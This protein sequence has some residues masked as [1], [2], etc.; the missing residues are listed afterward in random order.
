MAFFPPSKP[1]LDRQEG[2]GAFLNK[3]FIS[4]QN[5]SCF[6]NSGPP[7][8]ST[9][10]GREAQ[11]RG[12]QSIDVKSSRADP[13]CNSYVTLSKVEPPEVPAYFRLYE[14]GKQL[15]LY[16]VHI[17]ITWFYIL[18]DIVHVEHG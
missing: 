17:I 11:Y 14:S 16:D 15:D 7:F 4:F 6:G 12:Q 5:K 1:A 18:N 3:L 2:I 8:P 13:P 9:F 10:F